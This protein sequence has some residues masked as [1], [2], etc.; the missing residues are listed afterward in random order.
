MVNSWV[1]EDLSLDL[2]LTVWVCIGF[3]FDSGGSVGLHKQK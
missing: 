3:G 2:D 1:V